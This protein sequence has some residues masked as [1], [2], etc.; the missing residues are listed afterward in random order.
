MGRQGTTE[1]EASIEKTS[2]EKGKTLFN[3]PKLGGSTNEES[4]NSCH[5]AGEGLE[6]A[7]GKKSF[8]DGK[9]HSL[10]EMVN[11]C[12]KMTLKGSPPLSDQ[13]LKDIVAYICSLKKK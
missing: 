5:P 4:C 13:D 2:I 1:H 7:C 3:D 11:T 8:M 9:V 12:A 10:D 6:K